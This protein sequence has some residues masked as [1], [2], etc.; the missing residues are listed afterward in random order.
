M[1]IKHHS[2]HS[3]ILFKYFQKFHK[4]ADIESKKY[5]KRKPQKNF[6]VRKNSKRKYNQDE[7][8]SIA[9]KYDFEPFYLEELDF[10][11]NKINF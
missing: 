2:F 8:L 11:T 7:L 10:Q 9:E 1:K 6:L 4:Y 5:I 3:E